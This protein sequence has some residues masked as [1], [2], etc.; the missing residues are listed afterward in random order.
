MT[1]ISFLLTFLFMVVCLLTIVAI[2]LQPG[3][4]GSLAS[5]G[6]GLESALGTRANVTM[7]NI[8][9][10]LGCLLFALAGLLNRLRC[11]CHFL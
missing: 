9:I 5:L 6:G 2:L 7:R 3:R 1:I 11:I 8:T 10:I 4:G